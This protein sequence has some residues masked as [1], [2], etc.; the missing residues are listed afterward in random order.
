MECRIVFI[1]QILIL[2][3][4]VGL[5]D[6]PEIPFILFENKSELEVIVGDN[7]EGNFIADSTHHHYDV[8]SALKWGSERVSPSHSCKLFLSSNDSWRTLFRYY[9]SGI[10]NSVPFYVFDAQKVDAV[11]IDNIREN[12][13]VLVRYDFSEDDMDRLNWS[14]CYPPD[15]SMKDVHM[16]PSYEEQTGASLETTRY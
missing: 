8:Y 12:Y 7:H 16:Y 15:E 4:C 13:D 3:A 6:P 9:A 2:P 10:D 14:F 5:F 11:G 1:A